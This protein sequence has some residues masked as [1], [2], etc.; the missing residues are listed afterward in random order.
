M[1]EKEDKKAQ[2]IIKAQEKAK[3]IGH[4][5]CNL[6]I[7]CPCMAYTEHSVCVCWEKYEE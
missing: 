1:K 2:R 3:E 7:Q 4:C 5:L 6:A